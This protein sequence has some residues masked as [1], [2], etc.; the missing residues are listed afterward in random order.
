MSRFS[1]VYLGC[2]ALFL[3]SVT[4]SYMLHLTQPTRIRIMNNKDHI[5]DGMGDN[6]A[7][8]GFS[9]EA[10][11]AIDWRSLFEGDVVEY[12]LP[13]TQDSHEK[14]HTHSLAAVTYNRK[15]QPLYRRESE[16]DVEELL[17]YGDDDQKEMVL[18]DS[19]CITAMID[20]FQYTQVSTS[21]I[22]ILRLNYA[23]R[24][25]IDSVIF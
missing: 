6:V 1:L 16:S 24:M 3:H 13:T 23:Y 17:L 9:T 4:N 12:Q 20:D 14:A 7:V 5:N 19:I 18:D 15:L 8:I 10:N 2:L 25:W 21:I 11:G 22:H